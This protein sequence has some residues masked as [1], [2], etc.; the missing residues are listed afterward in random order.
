MQNDPSAQY[1]SNAVKG[2]PQQQ[3]QLHANNSRQQQVLSRAS[4]A[5]TYHSYRYYS[6][7]SQDE[8]NVV[9][10]AAQSPA[11]AQFTTFG[12]HLGSPYNIDE[13]TTRGWAPA[14]PNGSLSS[15]GRIGGQYDDMHRRMTDEQ[16][17][18]SHSVGAGHQSPS[19]WGDHT[20]MQ[21]A[22]APG[23]NNGSP[24]SG[25]RQQAGLG[26]H[27]L[28]DGKPGSGGQSPSWQQT[29][30][31]FDRVGSSAMGLQG[32]GPQAMAMKGSIS[33]SSGQLAPAL[34]D[35]PAPSLKRTAAEADL[36]DSIDPVDESND[37]DDHGESSSQQAPRKRASKGKARE[38]NNEKRFV[39]LIR[40]FVYDRS[41]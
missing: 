2:S 15:N 35:S 22:S 14:P 19:Q 18:R 29:A 39:R 10:S 36:G 17:A 38:R 31:M 1:Y 23:S 20:N 11:N 8:P 9:G 32:P 33:G 40:S 24:W 7:Q 12:D 30:N 41:C 26:Y 21:T 27:R 6:G 13:G 4:P 3:Q 34:P 28:N 16:I 37:G 25:A 5:Y